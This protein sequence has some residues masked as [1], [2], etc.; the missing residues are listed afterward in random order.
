M[1]LQHYMRPSRYSG[2]SRQGT[3]RSEH[4]IVRFGGQSA[5]KRACHP[6]RKQPCRLS[7]YHITD[8][9][10]RHKAVKQM[11]AVVAAA[12]QMQIEVD[13]GWRCLG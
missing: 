13:L 11:V 5:G 8:F 9:G 6:Q 12:G 3:C 1:L 2:F 7:V 4:E 10:E